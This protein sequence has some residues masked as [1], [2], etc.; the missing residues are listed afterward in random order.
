MFRARLIENK[1]YYKLRV[2]QIFLLFLLLI[3]G[4]IIINFYE[5][6][7][8]IAILIL[9]LYIGMII[10]VV[11]NQKK[12]RSVTGNKLIEMD[13]DEIR[14]K[15]KKGIE[16][17][18]IKLNNIEKIILKDQYSMPQET[19]KEVGQELTGK[20]KQNYIIINQDN[21][22]RRFDFEFDS[23]YMINQLNDLIKSW[24]TKGYNIESI[25]KNQ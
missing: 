9:A 10:L 22:E 19:M 18:K 16:E 1:S 7:T 17:E 5:P 13:N 23:Y 8:W 24:K 21:E 12:I 2:K 4:N 3:P 6:P 11:R 14:I 20:I 25:N 15:S